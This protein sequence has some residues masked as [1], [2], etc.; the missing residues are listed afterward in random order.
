MTDEYTPTTEE[1]RSS[2]ASN[3]FV[4]RGEFEFELL[5][6]DEAG[7]EFDRWLAA[8]DAEVAAKAWDEGHDAG[9]NSR[10]DDAIRGWMSSGVHESDAENP[11]RKAVQ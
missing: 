10:H 8:H 7:A 11:Y 6:E 5:A 1:V 3:Q 4:Q 9:W 2:F